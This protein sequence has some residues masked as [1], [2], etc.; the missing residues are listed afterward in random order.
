[1]TRMRAETK[2]YLEREDNFCK[3][4]KHSDFNQYQ[5]SKYAHRY[6]KCSE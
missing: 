6:Y 3:E 5:N 2:I 4:K 1:M